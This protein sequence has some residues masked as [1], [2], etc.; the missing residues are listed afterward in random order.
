MMLVAYL[1]L[2]LLDANHSAWINCVVHDAACVTS[3]SQRWIMVAVAL[4]AAGGGAAAR[5]CDA[6]RQVIHRYRRN[7]EIFLYGQ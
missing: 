4:L 7:G 3:T 5:N 6:V 1:A 2:Q